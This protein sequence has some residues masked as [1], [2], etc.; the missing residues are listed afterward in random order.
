V[1]SRPPH[2]ADSGA[3]AAK[4]TEFLARCTTHSTDV[5]HQNP[6]APGLAVAGESSGTW[7]AVVF[8]THVLDCDIADGHSIAT[9][10]AVAPCQPIG[11]QI[12][13]FCQ[14]CGAPGMNATAWLGAFAN[15]VLI[16]AF[17]M[18]AATQSV[19]L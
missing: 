6:G 15:R 13:R 8:D 2:F 7:P 1:F 14:E 18:P 4:R 3:E 16:F 17:F 19:K 11:A 10:W 9:Q 12:T 5:G